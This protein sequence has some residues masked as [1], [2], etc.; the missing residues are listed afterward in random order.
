MTSSL[1]IR[2]TWKF[3]AAH[4]LPNVHPGHKCGRLHGH[5]YQVTLTV[6][7]EIDPKYGWVM[8]FGEL[9]GVCRGIIDS[10]DH[11]TLN[12]IEGLR[13]PTSELLAVWLFGQ[14]SARLPG[15]TEVAV[16]EGGTSSVM[17][18]G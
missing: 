8:D 15:L 11:R 10:L 18:R 7:G 3:D 14:V 9:D 12:D 5:T 2:R 4:F 6:L 13:N 17:F 1:E 16:S